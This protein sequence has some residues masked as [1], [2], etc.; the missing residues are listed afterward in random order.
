MSKKGMKW[1]AE[2]RKRQSERLKGKPTHIDYSKRKLPHKKYECND[3]RIINCFRWMQHRC[4]KSNRKCAFPRTTLG[5]QEFVSEMGAIPESIKRPSVGRIDHD[6]GYIKGNIKWE[7]YNYN[8][9]KGR[10]TEQEETLFN[11]HGE[12]QEE[13]IPF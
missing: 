5:F 13:E 4:L 10:R 6:F 12:R 2:S 9:W 11:S 8:V 7:E 3:K 1:N